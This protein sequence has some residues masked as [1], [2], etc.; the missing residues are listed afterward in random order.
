MQNNELLEGEEFRPIE[1]ARK[2]L[3]S[4]MGRVYSTRKGKFKKLKTINGYAFVGIYKGGR[5]KV[6][7]VPRLVARTFLPLPPIN[8]SQLNVR[9]INGD[10]LD[11]RAE[12]LEW[13]EDRKRKEAVE[14]VEVEKKEVKSF[15]R[16]VAQYSLEGDYIASYR[17]SSLAGRKITGGKEGRS[18]YDCAR[19]SAPTAYGYR[20]AFIT[21]EEYEKRIKPE[22]LNPLPK[23]KKKRKSKKEKEKLRMKRIP[24][25][26]GETF[27]PFPVKILRDF[28]AISNLGRI[29][30]ARYGKFM[31]VQDNGH[32]WLYGSCYNVS[33]LVEQAYNEQQS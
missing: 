16:P 19:G 22:N 2:Y 33:K 8:T 20:W 30:N 32:I 17:S 10:K 15:Y 5:N 13:V 29:Y 26:A 23:K 24:T 31:P 1:G 25:R 4:N 3:I 28:L 18:V 12:N 27:V 14:T 7:S 11:N 21:P 6:V 9:H